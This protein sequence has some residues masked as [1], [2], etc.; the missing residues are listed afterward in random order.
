VDGKES[1]ESL[2]YHDLG[3][4]CR[5]QRKAAKVLGRGVGYRRMKGCLWKLN[6]ETKTRGIE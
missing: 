2:K 5:Y 3:L 4:I 6:L 1:V